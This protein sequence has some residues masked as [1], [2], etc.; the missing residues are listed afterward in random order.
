MDSKLRKTDPVRVIALSTLL[1]VASLFLPAP[2]ILK[3]L[4]QRPLKPDAL[5]VLFIGNSFTSGGNMP[6]LVESL[7]LGSK[8]EIDSEMIAPGGVTLYQHVNSPQTAAKLKERHWDVVVLQD[9]S[10]CT[11]EYSKW[12]SW[13]VTE[14]VKQVRAVGSTPL[15]YMTWADL[16]KDSDQNTITAAY[17]S[18]GKGLNV[19]VVPVGIAWQ[20]AAPLLPRGTLHAS[21]GHHPSLPGALLTA[22][23]FLQYFQK[24]AEQP[25][26]VEVQAPSETIY[27]LLFP[28]SLR[29][30]PT[31]LAA[32][33][34]SVAQETW[35]DF[36]KK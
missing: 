35:T 9:C 26:D 36:E 31:E 21:D 8:R 16:G 5:H 15:L 28:F 12:F 1:I 30:A 13:E 19:E 34:R 10:T 22:Y 20:H 14:M 27:E 25:I 18:I 11:L 33:L 7:S 24:D 29:Y 23:M 6:T 2:E 3:N 17:L 32:K 4:G